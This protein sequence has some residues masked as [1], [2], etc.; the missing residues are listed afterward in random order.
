MADAADSKSA[1]RKGVGVRLPSPALVSFRRFAAH[2]AGGSTASGSLTRGTV[3]IRGR[4]CSDPDGQQATH[5]VPCATQDTRG[6][7]A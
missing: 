6:R 5:Q 1:A 2:L 7:L 4:S 3:P